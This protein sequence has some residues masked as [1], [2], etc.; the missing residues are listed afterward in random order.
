MNASF[1]TG[2][3]LIVVVALGLFP[4]FAS[5]ADGECEITTQRTACPGKEAE[6][7]KPYDGKNPT[8]DIR[9]AASAEVCKATAEQSSKIVRKGTLKGK[10]VVARFNKDSNQKFEFSDSSECS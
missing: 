3:R 4:V 8:V 7:L 6:V 2:K 10:N 5:A 1:K 9:A